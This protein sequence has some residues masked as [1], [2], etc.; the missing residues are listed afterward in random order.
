MTNRKTLT[1]I[2]NVLVL[3]TICSSFISCTKQD[4]LNTQKSIKTASAVP[5]ISVPVKYII[6]TLKV[7]SGDTF[8]GILQSAELPYENIISYFNILTSTGFSTIYP[9]DSIIIK[10]SE[11]GK[12]KSLSLLNKKE[13]WFHVKHENGETKAQKEP[14]KFTTYLCVAKGTLNSSLSEDMFNIGVGDALVF[15]LADIFAWDINFFMDPRKGDNFEVVFEKKYRNGQFH[16]YGKV[17]SAK[18][19]NAGFTHYAF[20]LEDSTGTLNYYDKDGNSVQKQFLKAPLNFRRISSGFSYN[21][22]HPVLGIRRPHLGIDYA[23][24]TGTPVYAAADGK[25]QFSGW[26]GGYGNHIRITHG[27][28]YT[29]FYGHLHRINKGIRNGAH[30]KQGQMIGTVGSTGLSTG[31]HLDYRMK[32]GSR[33]VNPTSV[34]L[35][36]KESVDESERLAFLAQRDYLLKLHND[37]FNGNGCFVINISIPTSHDNTALTKNSIS[38]NDLSTNS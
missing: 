31:P 2:F 14:V 4:N 17:L 23:A 9:G 27:G 34:T 11:E 7:K 13:N 21:R 35:P 20:G 8:A 28:A 15:K 29:T 10:T 6:K 16:S 38:S 25:V 1:L 18:Y 36:S 19:V 12:V 26:K 24:P 37:R 33:F 30:V 32:C 5:A 22:K 3:I